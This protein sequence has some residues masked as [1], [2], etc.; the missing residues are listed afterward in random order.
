MTDTKVFAVDWTKPIELHDG[1]PVRLCV[2]G[3]QIGGPNPDRDGDYWVEPEARADW[4][5]KCI[6]SDGRVFGMRVV[7]NR[8]KEPVAAPTPAS[9]GKLDTHVRK[10]QEACA[11]YLEPTTY[12]ARHPNISRIGDCLW[13][14]EFSMPEP[15]HSPEAAQRI[16]ARRTEAFVS[17]II[18][19]LDGPEQREAQTPT[20]D[21]RDALIAELVEV[22]GL[23]RGVIANLAGHCGGSVATVGTI[24]RIEKA[25]TRVRE[26]GSAA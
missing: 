22:A 10:M 19:M 25:L 12:V 16:E 7:R 14:R 24:A 1:T 6:G 17:D 9:H 5:R 20:P 23:A 2:D 21:P 13:V 3:F 26:H 8:I 4:D 15:T 18:Y 11:N